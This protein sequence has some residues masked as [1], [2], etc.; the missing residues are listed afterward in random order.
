ME[1]IME[2]VQQWGPYMALPII[3]AFI[4]Q[5]LKKKVSFFT[6][7][8]G[9]RL[10]HFLPLVLGILGGLLLPE[11]T[12]QSKLLIGGGLGSLSLFLYKLVT[13]SLARRVHLEERLTRKSLDLDEMQVNKF[14]ADSVFENQ[15]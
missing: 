4:T 1:A 5:G 7:V 11:E 9:L 10:L 8:W 13:V 2:F 15:D 6:T 12:W 3:V 14:I